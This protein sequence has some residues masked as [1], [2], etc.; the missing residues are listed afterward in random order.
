M[1]AVSDVSPG[2]ALEPL[3][4]ES[5][6]VE[7]M[8]TMAAMLQDPNPIHYDVEVVKELGMGDRPVNQG[9]LNIAYLL[10]LVGRFAGGYGAIR[11]FRTRFLG[12]VFG[13]DRLECTGTVT[14]VDADA[15][16]AEL[17]IQAV[18]DGRPVLAG[19]ATVRLRR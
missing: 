9:P 16:T 7:R 8:K 17:E 14:S 10:D 1:P 4:I 11:D 2:Q 6:D 5:I 19:A 12:N 18:V 3:V 15:G 13:G